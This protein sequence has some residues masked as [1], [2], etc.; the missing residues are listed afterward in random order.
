MMFVAWALAGAVPAPTARPTLQVQFE[1][2]SAALANEKWDEAVA[3]FEAIEA[4][5]SLSPRTRSVVLM[6]KGKALYRLHHDDAAKK[7]LLEGLALAPTEDAAMREDRIDTLFALAGLERAEFDY[8]AARHHLEQS[9]ALAAAP[10][11]E[12]GSLLSAA[13][14]TMFDDS[15]AALKF[16]DDAAR[17]AQTHK[18]DAVV[19]AQIHE[20]RGR[21]FLNQENVNGAVAEFQIALKDLG[22]LTE[23]TDLN[24]VRVRSDLA[25]AYMLQ[26]RPDKAHEYLEMTGEGRLPD[27]PFASAARTDLPPCAGNLQPS[28]SAVVEFGIA[29]D[30]TVSFASPVYASRPGPLA[31]ELARAVSHWSW[32]ASEVAKI[33][34][35]YRAVTRVQ[36]RCSLAAGER[37]EDLSLLLPDIATWLGARGAAQAAAAISA[38]VQAATIRRE[39]DAAEKANDKP[40]ALIGWLIALAESPTVDFEERLKL[41]GRALGL[42]EAQHAPAALIAYLDLSSARIRGWSNWR[43]NGRY[44][45]E[46]R[47]VLLRPD[48]SEDVRTTAILRLILGSPAS[49]SG[50][51]TD[52]DKVL[53]LVIDEK[54]IDDRDP[55]KIGA[56]IRL[57]SFQ[58][59][60]GQVAAAHDSFVKT[61]LSARQC[62]LVD[63]K[64][65][66]QKMGVT[67]NDYPTEMIR[68][69]ISGWTRIEF[70]V[71]PNGQTANRRAVISYPP[72]A[73]GDAAV[74]GMANAR[75]TQTY[76]PQGEL[77]CGGASVNF[78]FVMPQS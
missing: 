60:Q 46:I 17:I 40:A 77:G 76:R 35:F 44:R 54:R 48:I 2:A 53:R 51:V 25:L 11:D 41:Y 36:V 78:R 59:Q 13:A 74:K 63:A 16:V 75:Y 39:I 62:S 12:L 30:G 70:D 3:G 10:G 34:L 50:Y 68:L 20:T 52:A 43:D 33:P 27:G 4:R 24:D 14:I 65:A 21:V 64:P 49:G 1:A 55:V 28:D 29:D 31:V 18:V 23:K 58:A 19:D 73:F 72:L 71:L 66:I 69:G 67:S 15:A 7:A 22:G 38:D 42:A 47:R 37:P 61:G 45:A 26:K 8:V 57:A 6:R 5:Q 32:R 9:R 56:L